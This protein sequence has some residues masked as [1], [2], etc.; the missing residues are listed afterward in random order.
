MIEINAY[1][2]PNLLP[3]VFCT[4]PTV[5][6]EAIGPQNRQLQQGFGVGGDY[7]IGGI[8]NGIVAVLVWLCV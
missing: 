7:G 2:D 5:N 6:G 4:L 8:W 3:T 1:L